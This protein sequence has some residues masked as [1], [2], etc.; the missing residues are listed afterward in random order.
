V[1]GV[2]KAGSVYRALDA[3][4]CLA[5]FRGRARRQAVND[6]AK[7]DPVN[8]VEKRATCNVC[9][10]EDVFGLLQG[11][12]P[13]QVLQRLPIARCSVPFGLALQTAEGD[14][15]HEIA[16]QSQEQQQNGHDQ[17]AGGGGDQRVIGAMHILKLCQTQRDGA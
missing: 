9:L 7:A 17:Q 4:C 5:S 10:V 12:S 3:A 11:A 2:G 16:L 15:L 8:G 13:R 6:L 1:N 14:T